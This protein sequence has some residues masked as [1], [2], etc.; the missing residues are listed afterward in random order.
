M[1]V[2]ELNCLVATHVR[3]QPQPA[4]STCYPT[5]CAEVE[6]NNAWISIR[7]HSKHDV[8]E[9]AIDNVVRNGNSDATIYNMTLDNYST[10]SLI[11]MYILNDT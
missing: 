10:T 4:R 3:T 9:G 8:D 5:L 7:C 1:S 6:A 2:C 11:L